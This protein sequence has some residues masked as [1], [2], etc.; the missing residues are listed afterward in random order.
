[1]EPGDQIEK[2]AAKW[3]AERD[4]GDWTPKD[5]AALDQWLGESSANTVAYIRLEAAWKR[6]DRLQ[7]LGA[8]F[9]KGKVPTPEEFN[10]SPFFDDREGGGPRPREA[11]DLGSVRRYRTAFAGLAASLLLV[12]A[13]STAWYFWPIGPDY[14]TPIGGTASV[15]MADGSKVTLNTDSAI[16]VAVTER[17]RQVQLD[18][19]EAFFEVAKD[20]KRPFVV[21]VGKKRVIAVGTK[22]SVRRIDSDIRIVVTEGT[23]RVESTSTPLHR[24][25]VDAAGSALPGNDTGSATTEFPL[26]AG[27]IARATG[28]DLLVQNATIPQA[29]ESLSWRT[30]YLIF[31]E[32]TLADAVAEFNR[33]NLRKLVID[34]PSVASIR[35]SGKFRTADFEAFVRLLEGGFPIHAQHAQEQ[36]ILTS[37]TTM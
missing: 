31:R 13:V 36:I 28:D 24:K 23:V 12:F 2:R 3:L 10:L 9:P 33:Y 19:G 34:D 20:P 5:Q 8:G 26:A 15:P 7:A 29:E 17:E 18:H 4:S 35:L 30:G 16:R 11:R 1:M 14:K 22:F 37:S 21:S 6:A 32:T 27:S 25:E